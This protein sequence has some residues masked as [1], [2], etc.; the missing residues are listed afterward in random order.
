M[1]AHKAAWCA[2]QQA[3]ALFW[4]MHDWIFNTQGTWSPA[5]VADATA[6]FRAEALKL[7]TDATK[8]DACVAGADV[9]GDQQGFADSVW[10]PGKNP[11]LGSKSPG[12]SGRHP[13][14]PWPAWE[15]EVCPPI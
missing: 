14:I 11:V 5:S 13:R 8:F 7:G 2:G 4:K 15:R 3:P 12:R 10:F 9:S 6:Q 1:P